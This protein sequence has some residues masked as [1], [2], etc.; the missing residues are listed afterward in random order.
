MLTHLN[1]VSDLFMVNSS[2]S[3]FLKWNKDK[4]LSLLPYYHIY[5][6]SSILGQYNRDVMES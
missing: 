3:T 2:E 6:G 5:G 4:I 1:V